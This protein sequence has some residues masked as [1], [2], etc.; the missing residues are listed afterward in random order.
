MKKP[1][2]KTISDNYD[3]FDIYEG[4][5]IE[6]EMQRAT[7]MKQPID[8][9][10]PI[11]YTDRK[12]GVI[13]EYNIRTDRWEIAQEAMDIVSKTTTAKRME[14]LAKRENNNTNDT[15]TTEQQETA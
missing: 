8:N 1:N 2:F 10:S 3:N 6:T 15:T 13:A 5:S 12:D 7:Q 4:E 14:M 9:G 11:L